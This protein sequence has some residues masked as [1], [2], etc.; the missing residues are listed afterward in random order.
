MMMRMMVMA[1]RFRG[2]EKMKGD[3]ISKGA[4]SGRSKLASIWRW[5]EQREKVYEAG[6]E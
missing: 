3:N 4:Q 6:R 2:T 5:L 1:K